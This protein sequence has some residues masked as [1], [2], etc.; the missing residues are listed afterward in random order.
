MTGE[1]LNPQARIRF[2]S[3]DTNLKAHH[4]MLASEAFQRAEDLALLQYARVLASNLTKSQN[5][6]LDAM[7]NGAKML[8]VQEFIHE[9]RM[10][11]EKPLEI[12]PPGM[13]RRLNHNS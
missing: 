8:G 2:Q 9:F 12:V 6:Q 10:L 13:G 7:L 1:Q 5:P 4:E 3:V 11:G